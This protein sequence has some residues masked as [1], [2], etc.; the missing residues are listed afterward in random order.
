SFRLKTIIGVATIEALLLFIIIWNSLNYL[1][2]SNEEEFIKRTT[3]AT[4]L[5]AGM[6]KEAI[7]TTDLASLESF[8]DEILKNPDILYARVISTSMG[9]LADGGEKALL[10][11]PFIP[12]MSIQDAQNGF[13][14]AHAKISEAGITYGSVEIGFNILQIQR[15][16]TKAQKRFLMLSGI[17]MLL[18]ALFSFVLGSY[19]TRQLNDLSNAS[20][21]ITSGNLGFQITVRGRDELART[22]ATFN[23]M[24]QDLKESYQR[25]TDSLADE[26]RISKELYESETRKRVILEGVLDGI[27][28]IDEKGIIETFNPAAEKLFGYRSDDVIGQNVELIIPQK[29]QKKH[30]QYIDNY[31]KSGRTKMIGI[32]RE[33][34]GLRRNGNEFPIDLGVSEIM[35][36]DKVIFTGIVRDITDRKIA[37][38]NIKK[39]QEGLEGMVKE[40]TAEL[41]RTQD[42]LL[43]RAMESGR[44]QLSAITLHNIGNSITPVKIHIENMMNADMM[45]TISFLEQCYRELVANQTNLSQYVL[46]DVKGQNIFVYMGELIQSLQNQEKS[47]QQ[48]VNQI[49]SSLTYVTET[50]SLQQNYAAREKE[51]KEIIDLN[52]LIRDTI[53][54]QQSALDKRQISIQTFFA[55]RLQRMV[56]DKNRLMQVIANFIK[57]SYEAIDAN[58]ESGNEKYLKIKTFGD[59]SKIGFEILDSGIGLTPEQIETV[60]EFGQS[61]KG[62]SG[63]GLFYCKMFVDA[64]NGQLILESKG[65]EKGVRAEVC[66]NLM[67]NGN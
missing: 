34:T 44:A 21:Q 18:S 20:S 66:F 51:I 5:F 60:F 48:V 55:N 47:Q 14:N 22:A 39:Y 37:E 12:H 56:I 67:K 13:F 10:A 24:S 30:Q 23:K 54:M 4:T 63:I 43:T 50:L 8:I 57:N 62:S 64:N 27:I 6:T 59:E 45:S 17:E 52:E 28:T 42:R 1:K 38:K 16:L 36:H 11:Q 25:L 46:E 65:R 31:I 3:T 35:L 58:L 19:L 32:G 53:T 40:R 61:Y 41:K 29:H 7:L 15:V 26:R 49:K 33:T 9:L 2:S